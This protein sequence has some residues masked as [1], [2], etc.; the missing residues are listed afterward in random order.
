L[1]S[2]YSRQI[3]FAGIGVL[4]QEKL[5]RSK[6]LLVGCGALGS[7]Q[8]EILVRAGIGKLTIVDRDF[9]EESNLQRQALFAEQDCRENLPKAIAAARRLRAINGSV[10]ISEHVLDINSRT[11]EPLL[12][13][14]NLIMDGTDNF[15]TR[16]LLNDASWKWGI[17][18]IYGA[19]VGSY[20]ICLPITPPHP[21]C[22]RCVME[23]MPSPGSSP[24]CDTIGIIAPI[25]HQV[26]A[27][28][29][30]AALKILTGNLTQ[31][32]QRLLTVDLW[33]WRLTTIDF[34]NW[35]SDQSCPC[36]GEGRYEF[37]EGKH[38]G[39][40][41]SL[42]GRNAVQIWRIEPKPVN[43]EKIAARLAP[44]GSVTYN[45]FMLKAVVEDY[46]IA[47]FRDGRGIVRGTQ[48][49]D[50]ARSLYSKYIGN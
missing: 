16:F 23:E 25:V 38:E 5:G 49:L 21:P 1:N 43:F 45:E 39:R 33:D 28:Q 27:L 18:W 48:D 32:H 7:V 14:Q 6:V 47:L 35:R 8:A 41:Q 46:E 19:C 34:K 22:L 31:V 36:C 20:G 2:R 3:M 26:A 11:L 15:E 17:P 9:I 40:T 44:F 29:T 42:C 4:G 50:E 37:L 30:A 12:E 13:E 10:K 24:T